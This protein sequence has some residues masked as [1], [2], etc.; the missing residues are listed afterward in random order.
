MFREVGADRDKDRVEPARL[1]LGQNVVDP[2]VG[3]ELDAHL[4]DPSDLL[5]Q[6]LARES[7]CRNAEM[8]H[9]ARQWAGVVD[10]HLMA[11]PRQM[12][13]GGQSARPG[14]DHQHALA[15]SNLVDRHRPALL[16]REVAQEPLD[17]VNAHGA[18]EF[19][20]IAAG[21]A[22]VIADTSVHRRQR[23]VA[24][25]RFPCGAV[26]SRLRQCEPRLDVLTG[27][28]GRVAGRKQVDINWSLMTYCAS[29]SLT[30][31]INRGSDIA[32]E[33][34]HLAS[35]S[36]GAIGSRDSPPVL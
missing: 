13:G 15:G 17:S 19:L 21:F 5:H 6:V 26:L 27:G 18:V 9:A 33:V 12:I 25:Q 24:D 11:E 20:A 35:P 28:A 32:G 36:T 4:L 1:L 7:I 3:H 29:P 2:V 14:T 16:R 31:E 8:Q 23:V 10:L 30:S 34:V 22:G